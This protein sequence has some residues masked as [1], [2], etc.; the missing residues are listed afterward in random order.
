MKRRNFLKS[1]LVAGMTPLFVKGYSMNQLGATMIPASTCNF[2]DRILVIVYLAGA[3]DVI[4]MA[5]PINDSSGNSQVAAYEQER[6]LIHLEQNVLTRLDS[7]AGGS[8]QLGLHPSLVGTNSI[9]SMYDAGKVSLIQRVS[10]PTPNRSHFASEDIMLRGIDGTVSNSSQDEGWLGRWLMDRYPTYT[11]LPFGAEQDPLGIIVGGSPGTGFHTQAEHSVEINL[12]GQDPSGFYNV[13]SSLSGEPIYQLPNS[14]HGRTLD[15]I[16]KVEQSTQVYSNRIST[17]FNA[18]TNNPA[19]GYP[20]SSFGNQLK[21]IARFISG[22]SR[23]KVYMAR[24]GG[25]DNHVAINVPGNT[26]TGTHAT[27]LKDMNDS[28]AAFHKDLELTSNSSKVLTVV[29]SE[30]GRKIIENGSVGTDHGTM[31]SMWLIGD[32]SIGGIFGDNI[33]IANK[34]AQGAPNANQLQYDY[35][36]VFGS[37]LQDW[38]G[39]SN[40]AINEV[41]PGVTPNF[42][43]IKSGETVDPSCYFV[44]TEPVDMFVR[45]KVFLGGFLNTATGLMDTSLANNGLIAYKQPYGN[46]KYSYYGDESVTVF[47]ANTVDWV[48]LEIVNSNNLVVGRQAVLL[49]NDGRLMNLN[50]GLQIALNG[51]YPEP[52]KISILHRNH[53]GVMVKNTIDAIDGASPYI[54]LTTG[55][56]T[57][58]GDAQLK[59]YNGVYAMYP[60][61]SDQN[62]LINTADYSFWRRSSTNS[63]PGY[64]AADFNGDGVTDNADYDQWKG[65]RSKIGNPDLYSILKR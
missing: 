21:T 30:F 6:P 14:E 9:K 43:P 41:F 65:N 38:M 4:N 20:N 5:V 37:I 3:N 16:S 57:V 18:G 58:D 51:L 60:G 61:D 52:F 13:I 31:S 55:V 59:N 44:P 56:G 1:G 46:T 26:A 25:W 22:G 54:N 34:D 39:A 33:D 32:Q 7:T 35:R 24:K 36:R 64:G 53:I 50:G 49:R 8:K 2:D 15:Y 40:A 45:G 28:I 63:T 11:G 23:T 62:G 48:M 19:A 10:Y 47:P 29:F 12:S 17:V 42:N 27:L